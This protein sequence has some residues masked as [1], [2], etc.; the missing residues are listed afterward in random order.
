MKLH[1]TSLVAAL[2]LALAPL[3]SQAKA[4]NN[5]S[6]RLGLSQ[7]TK[8]GESKALGPDLWSC[9][10]NCPNTAVIMVKL[11]SITSVTKHVYTVES[12]NVLEVVIDTTGNN[13][14]RFYYCSSN[15]QDNRLTS[16]LSNTRDLLDKRQKDERKNPAK[17]YP[18]ATHSHNVEYQLA[19][20]KSIKRIFDSVS[21][22]WAKNTPTNIFIKD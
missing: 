11:S 19:C 2:C 5:D 8:E 4:D 15:K 14:I 16:R 18:T 1:T 13:S 17:E 7:V 21:N 3:S 22:A 6:D 10:I 12:Q 20:D 9:I